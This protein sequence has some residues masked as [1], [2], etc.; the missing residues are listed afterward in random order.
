M[1]EVDIGLDIST[2]V[3]GVCVLEH[4]TNNL[5]DLFSIKMTSTKFKDFWDKALFF[6]AEIVKQIKPTWLI[7]RVFVEE[8][9]KRFSPGFSSADTIITLAKMNAVACLAMLKVYKVKPTFVNVRTGRAQLGIK[10][11]TKDKT[12]STKEKVFEQVLALNPSFPWEQH[13]AKTGK[14]VGKL[15]YDKHN[16]DMADSWVVCRSGQ[17]LNP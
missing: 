13:I 1:Q 14:S 6:E 3:V 12:K 16:Q 2:S 9:A 11:N 10:I 17:T 5:V 4:K 15:V 8:A 7:K